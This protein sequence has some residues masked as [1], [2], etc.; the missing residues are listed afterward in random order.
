M[1]GFIIAAD[2]IVSKEK[3]NFFEK[4]IYALSM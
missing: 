4:P 1:N 2:L 3:Y